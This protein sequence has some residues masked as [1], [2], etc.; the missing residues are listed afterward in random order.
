[1]KEKCKTKTL[2]SLSKPSLFVTLMANGGFDSLVC[3][4]KAFNMVLSSSSVIRLDFLPK[5]EQNSSSSSSVKRPDIL[6]KEK[7]NCS[8]INIWMFLLFKNFYWCGA[9]FIVGTSIERY[10]AKIVKFTLGQ[11][12][13]PTVFELY[14]IWNSIYFTYVFF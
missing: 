12:L 3:L 13:L 1:M 6:T 10:L 11:N 8:W 5:K 9:N 14:K 7:Q 2:T 4:I